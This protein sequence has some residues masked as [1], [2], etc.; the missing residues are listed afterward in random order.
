MFRNL[1]GERFEN[2][3]R[4]AGLD[5]VFSTM[6]SNYGDFDNDGVLD[7]YLGTGEPNLATLIPNRM[8]KNVDGERFAEITRSS[9]T[10][11]LQKRHG[12]ACRLWAPH[13]G[14]APL[15]RHPARPHA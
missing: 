12:V 14:C 6:G 3:T 5:M 9:G 15:A 4:E 13:A 1:N 11:H 7:F 10:C 8:F 2:K